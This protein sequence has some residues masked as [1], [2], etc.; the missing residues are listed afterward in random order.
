VVQV[1]EEIDSLPPKHQARTN[2][3][4][5]IKRSVISRIDLPKIGSIT[6]R[7]GVFFEGEDPQVATK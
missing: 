3:D 2:P 1:S 5:V 4:L 7:V 6:N